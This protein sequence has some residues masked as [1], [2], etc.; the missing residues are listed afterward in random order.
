M[1]LCGSNINELNFLSSPTS[2]PT[3]PTSSRYARP[4][5]SS[6]VQSNITAAAR[7]RIRRIRSNRRTLRR[8]ASTVIR[9]VAMNQ[10]NIHNEQDAIRAQSD[11][12]INSTNAA[13]LSFNLR[14]QDLERT[15]GRV[16]HNVHFMLRRLNEWKNDINPDTCSDELFDLRAATV[17]IVRNAAYLGNDGNDSDGDFNV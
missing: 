3:P 17:D 4:H 11:A 5:T 16:T 1:V 10:V 13:T 12:L 9:E 2:S 6:R 15:L 14:L 7:G 8:N